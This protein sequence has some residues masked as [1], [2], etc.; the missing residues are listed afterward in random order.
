M[1]TPTFGRLS[2]LIAA[3]AAAPLAGQTYLETFDSLT[4]NEAPAA[5]ALQ[6]TVI[7]APD[8]FGSGQVLHINDVS[9]SIASGFERNLAVAADQAYSNLYLTFDIRNAN[10]NPVAG[11][12]IDPLIFGV[13]A[14]NT[15]TGLT[16]NSNAN[17]FFNIEFSG[18]GTT[19]T[20]KLR[21]GGTTMVQTTYAFDA[22]HF[23]QIYANDHNTLAVPY[24]RPDTLLADDLAP[25]TVAI[26]VNGTLLG[27]TTMNADRIGGDAGMGRL[28]FYAATNVVP[29]FW[30]DNVSAAAIPA[31]IPEPAVT[32]LALG[33]LA[34]LLAWRRRRR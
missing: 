9:T 8:G 5:P 17:R 32:A 26:F 22:S 12:G 4:L 16:L 23:V 28:G 29:S 31:P 14:Y 2:V 27:Q 24:T 11:S 3:L 25:N 1:N 30:I 20:L 18:G 6:A 34:G 21:I 33:A 7:A 10:P 15:G 13:G 19:N